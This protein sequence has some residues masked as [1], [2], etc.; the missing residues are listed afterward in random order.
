VVC[1][2]SV[3]SNWEEQIREHLKGLEAL[4]TDSDGLAKG[5]EA[6]GGSKGAKGKGKE[7]KGLRVAIYHGKDRGALKLQALQV[8]G[9]AGGDD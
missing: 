2:L 7:G 5:E 6:G 8:G 3:M 1:P 9:G 4:E